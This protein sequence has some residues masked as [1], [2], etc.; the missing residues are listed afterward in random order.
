VLELLVN[1]L[2]CSLMAG[3]ASEMSGGFLQLVIKTAD[4]STSKSPLE[5]HFSEVQR[6]NQG[7]TAVSHQQKTLQT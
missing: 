2:T 5:Q 6:C 4:T 3:S 1:S 7:Q